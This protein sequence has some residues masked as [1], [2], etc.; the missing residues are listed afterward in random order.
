[1]FTFTF[2]RRNYSVA[3]LGIHFR[4]AILAMSGVVSAYPQVGLGLAP[5]REELNL[6]P[7]AAHS[8]VLTL[9]NTSSDP[10][11]VV[12]EMLDFYLDNTGTPQFGRDYPQ[13]SEFLV[14]TVAH[15]QPNGA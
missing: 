3:R 11:R 7:G 10:V 6:A 5:M 15:G 4:L 1:M 13:E 8:G 14:Q 12:T 9:A 2:I